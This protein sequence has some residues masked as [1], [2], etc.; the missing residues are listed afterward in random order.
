MISF[1]DVFQDRLLNELIKKLIGNISGFHRAKID[2]T[3]IPEISDEI[4]LLKTLFRGRV[5]AR[6]HS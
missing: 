3:V 1:S 5:V 2:Q 6:R 4:I